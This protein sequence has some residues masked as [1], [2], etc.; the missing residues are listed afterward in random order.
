MT[1]PCHKPFLALGFVFQPFVSSELPR[2]HTLEQ[3][4]AHPYSYCPALD[5]Y[6]DRRTRIGYS[7][8][9]RGMLDWGLDAAVVEQR[10][11]LFHRQGRV[12]LWKWL[13]QSWRI[14][15]MGHV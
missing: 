7:W 2:R 3:P 5:L 11:G 4:S 8:D 14:H 12:H 1:C 9:H 15:Q 13:R 10:M 6:K